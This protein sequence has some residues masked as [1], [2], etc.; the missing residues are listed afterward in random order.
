MDT[1]DNLRPDDVPFVPHREERFEP[2]DTHHLSI[3]I[4]IYELVSLIRV[5]RNS[6]QDFTR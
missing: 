5:V 3:G 6:C 2:N 4:P 1:R